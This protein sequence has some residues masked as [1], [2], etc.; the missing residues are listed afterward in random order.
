MTKSKRAE[1]AALNDLCR[2]AIGVAD[3]TSQSQGISAEN[4][5]MESAISARSSMGDSGFSG[6]SI[7]MPAISSTAA[8]TPATPPRP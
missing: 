1:I 4:D 5:P 8:R 2:M 6:R 7:S 3:R